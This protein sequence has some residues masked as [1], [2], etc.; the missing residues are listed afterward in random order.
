MGSIVT[1]KGTDSSIF[2]EKTC[3]CGVI[4]KELT[5]S[6]RVWKCK[7]CGKVN[8]R[9]ELAARNIKKF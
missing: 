8:H 6:D 4:N 2:N 9:D 1:Q 3:E 5:L 7:R